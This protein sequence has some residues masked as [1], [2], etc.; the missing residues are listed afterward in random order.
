MAKDWCSDLKRTELVSTTIIA[1]PVVLVFFVQVPYSERG[2]LP[3]GR[4]EIAESILRTATKVFDR[5]ACQ[6][7]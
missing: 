2:S 5:K 1:L 7:L 6:R 3:D 4:S